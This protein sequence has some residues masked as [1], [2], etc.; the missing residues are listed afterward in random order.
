MFSSFKD[1]TLKEHQKFVFRS[2]RKWTDVTH[3]VRNRHQIRQSV[4]Y[5]KLYCPTYNILAF[6]VEHSFPAWNRMTASPER[7]R[8]IRS[9]CVALLFYISL[10][11]NSS[12]GISIIILLPAG[13]K[14][15]RLK[16][17]NWVEWGESQSLA[18]KIFKLRAIQTVV[19]R[20]GVVSA[21]S[22]SV[23]LVCC[24]DCY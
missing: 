4:L 18:R 9:Y 19:Q 15:T 7:E 6:Q 13:T 12:S 10:V 16:A 23:T 22:M 17:E 21:A 20:Q 5:S 3:T 2:I 11:H 8:T 14:D 24:A 1:L